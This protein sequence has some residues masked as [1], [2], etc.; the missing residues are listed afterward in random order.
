MRDSS[1]LSLSSTSIFKSQSRVELYV[2]H[3]LLRLC[4]YYQ[5]LHAAE[6]KTATGLVALVIK[7]T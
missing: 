2:A 1:H 6:L 3:I 7:V 5:G 4:V